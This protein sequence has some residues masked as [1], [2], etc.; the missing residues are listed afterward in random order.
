MRSPVFPPRFFHAHLSINSRPAGSPIKGNGFPSIAWPAV[1][2]LSL[3]KNLEGLRL[4]ASTLNNTQ[5][6]HNNCDNQKEMNE[7][8]Y[9][10]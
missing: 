5:Q 4:Y 7:S 10:V 1:L 8:T 9:G 3:R 2:V 6:Y